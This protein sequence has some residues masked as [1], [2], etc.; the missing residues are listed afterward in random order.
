MWHFSRTSYRFHHPVCL[1]VFFL[2]PLHHPPTHSAS[3]LPQQRPS[4]APNHWVLLMPSL[5]SLT[6]CLSASVRVCV[7]VSDCTVFFFPPLQPII[8]LIG[9]LAFYTFSLSLRERCERVHF[10]DPCGGVLPE[11][12]AF[13]Q[14][15]SVASTLDH[16]SPTGPD[17]ASSRHIVTLYI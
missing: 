3:L 7:S 1:S 10:S 11:S 16:W 13:S 12:P 17:N 4:L 14:G 6:S 8:A 15:F 2:E 5:T 9:S